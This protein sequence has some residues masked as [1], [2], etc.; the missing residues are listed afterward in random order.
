M[1]MDMSMNRFQAAPFGAIITALEEAQTA[2][3]PD[4]AMQMLLPTLEG[5]LQALVTAGAEFRLDQLDI[6]LPQGTIQTQIVVDIAETD[7]GANFSW[8]GVLLAMTAN[9]DL[10]V[11]A[12]LFE[13]AAMMNPQAGSLIAMGILQQE[14][15][16]YVMKAEYAQGLVNVNGAPMPIPIPGLS[17]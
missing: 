5:D 12:E 7:A 8:P 6:T 9:I 11:P 14:G 17:P 2:P 10:R 15:E 4:L 16:D 13:L 3:D 1:S